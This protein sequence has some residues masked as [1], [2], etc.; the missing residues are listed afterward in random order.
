MH[1]M[2]EEKKIAYIACMADWDNSFKGSEITLKSLGPKVW[3]NLSMPIVMKQIPA[4]H[5]FWDG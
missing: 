1:Q 2:M 5:Q 4:E 3:N